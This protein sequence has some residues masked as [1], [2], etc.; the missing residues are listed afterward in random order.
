MFL[1]LNHPSGRCMYRGMFGCLFRDRLTLSLLAYM[2]CMVVSLVPDHSAGN[3]TYIGMILG[4]QGSELALLVRFEKEAIR[5]DI[6]AKAP[7]A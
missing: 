1:F 7:T 2:L 4:G 3:D 6:L 5:S